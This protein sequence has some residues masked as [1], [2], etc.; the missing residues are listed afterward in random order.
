MTKGMKHC[1]EQM[2]D[3]I[4]DDVVPVTFLPKFRE[5]GILV[6]DGGSSFLELRY[7][8]WCG[9]KLP[10]SLRDEWFDY[11]EAREIDPESDLVPPEYQT[12]QW[13]IANE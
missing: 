7:C 2:R 1:C 11:L 8:P 4:Q 3:A 5:Y 6:L 10:S 12:E 9:N 13:W